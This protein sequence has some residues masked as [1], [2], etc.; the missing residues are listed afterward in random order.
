MNKKY[1]VRFCDC[2]RI[3]L[4]PME[5]LD[6]LSEDP[7]NRYILQICQNCGAT[8]RIFLT[9]YMDGGYALNSVDIFD[10]ELMPEDLEHCRVIMNRGIPVPL[11]NNKRAELHI[12]REWYSEESDVPTKVDTQKLISEVKD[13]DKLKS[14]SGYISGIDWSGTPYD[15]SANM[16][17]ED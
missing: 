9:E 12:G 17:D 15:C 10:Y 5:Y 16:R 13:E 4:T 7:D 8:R 1:D 2:G 3:Q 6:W 14:I 11:M